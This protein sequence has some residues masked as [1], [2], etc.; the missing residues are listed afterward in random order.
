MKI[1]SSNP[2][3]HNIE[4]KTIVEF[5]VFLTEVEPK[6]IV[7]EAIQTTFDF[8]IELARISL[9][10]NKA[11]NFSFTGIVNEDDFGLHMQSWV[12]SRNWNADSQPTRQSLCS[13]I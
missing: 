4:N 12:W 7:K 1:K 2:V 9:V 13:G 10:I 5:S 8:R 3:L 6:S 11:H